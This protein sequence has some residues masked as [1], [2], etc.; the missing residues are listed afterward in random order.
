[1][2]GVMTAAVRGLTR[3][4]G[5]RGALI[6]DMEAGVPVAADLAD[7]VAETALAALTGSLFQ[8]TGEASRAAERGELRS[9]HLEASGGH[10]VAVGAGGLLVV[11]LAATS[12]QLG[13]VRV[14]ATRIAK[15]LLS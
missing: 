13:L 3:I 11:V 6:V 7:G 12:A 1:M 2:T 8:R 4:P 10:V 15:E 14:Q 5:V 9:V